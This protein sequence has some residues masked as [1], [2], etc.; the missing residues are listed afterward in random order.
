[1]RGLFNRARLPVLPAL[2][3]CFN[4][5]CGCVAFSTV[6]RLVCAQVSAEFQSALRMRGLFNHCARFA[7][8]TTP[9]VSIRLADAWP[10]QLELLRQLLARYGWFQSA[11]RMRGLF[12]PV[13]LEVPGNRRQVSIRLADAWPFQLGCGPGRGPG[14]VG[15]SIRLADAWPFQPGRCHSMRGYL[16]WFQSAL[17]MRGLFNGWQGD[18]CS[19]NRCVSIR[20]ADAWP[21]QLGRTGA[22]WVCD[23]SFNPPCG[24]VAFS[25]SMSITSSRHFSIVSIRLADAWPFQ[26]RPPALLVDTHWCFNPPCGCVAFSTATMTELERLIAEFQSAL[27]MRGLFNLHAS[28]QRMEHRQVSIRLADAWPFQQAFGNHLR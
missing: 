7:L 16:R 19:R 1:M 21:F 27:R 8:A 23:V 11:L 24:C 4:P 17:R 12:N 26:P 9:K 5:P 22:W 13:S 10:F 15:V 20:L 28:L 6:A 25:T 14:C 18:S 2:P 3:A